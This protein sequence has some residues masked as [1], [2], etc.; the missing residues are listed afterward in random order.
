MDIMLFNLTQFHVDIKWNDEYHSDD[1]EVIELREQFMLNLHE[2]NIAALNLRE[3]IQL[4]LLQWSFI[5]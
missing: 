1:E 5:K 4:H 3:R 2:P